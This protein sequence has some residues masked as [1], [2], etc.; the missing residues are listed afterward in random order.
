MKIL[1]TARL[2]LRTVELSD[3]PFYLNLL[4]DPGFIDNIGDRGIRTLEAARE[5]IRTGPL[6]MQATLGHSIYLV[7]LKGSGVAI[8][9]CGLIKRDT[10]SHV[11][12]GYAFLPQYCGH[13]YAFEAASAVV[14]YARQ[15]VGLNRL[16][17]ITSPENTASNKLLVKLG[18]QLEKLVFLRTDESATNL[19]VLDLCP[20]FTIKTNN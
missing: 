13:G 5:A 1:D 9:M 4:N 6:D 18:M 3:A 19:Y 10:L 14:T 17:A 20:Q 2:E 12:I 16:L 15:T 8:G 11:D 7:A